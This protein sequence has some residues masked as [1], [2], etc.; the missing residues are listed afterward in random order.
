MSDKIYEIVGMGERSFGYIRES[1]SD[2]INRQ[3]IIQAMQTTLPNLCERVE[4]NWYKHPNFSATCHNRQASVEFKLKLV[5]I[6]VIG[7]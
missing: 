7:V 4:I 5:P 6:R 3:R 2:S 1:H